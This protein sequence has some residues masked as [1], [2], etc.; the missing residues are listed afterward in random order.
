MRFVLATL[1]VVAGVLA[2]PLVLL[3]TPSVSLRIYL[4][5]LPV[6]FDHPHLQASVR[7][8]ADVHGVAICILPPFNALAF[9][10]PSINEGL[11]DSAHMSLLLN[12]RRRHI[13]FKKVVHYTPSSH[14]ISS[15]IRLGSAANAS[16]TL[17]DL[18]EGEGAL[19]GDH[20]ALADVAQSAAYVARA[21]YRV[22][23][24]VELG[25]IR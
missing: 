24:Q 7:S 10:C 2:V 20:Q 19:V 18:E 22:L 5:Y 6:E 14:A 12:L 25:L 16:L 8:L 15:L 1:T 4:R 3:M 9:L 13:L 21:L 11:H 17:D 23:V